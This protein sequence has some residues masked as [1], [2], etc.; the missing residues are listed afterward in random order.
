MEWTVLEQADD[1][2]VFVTHVEAKNIEEAYD[3]YQTM[4][5]GNFIVLSSEVWN[6]LR[7]KK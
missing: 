5:S 1:G 4:E 2:D 6:N 3:N 7:G